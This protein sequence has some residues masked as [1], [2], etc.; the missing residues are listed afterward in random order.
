MRCHLKSGISKP[1]PNFLISLSLSGLEASQSYAS[2]EQIAC[3]A[4]V[5]STFLLLE[6]VSPSYVKSYLNCLMDSVLH[7]QTHVPEA[8][9]CS[10]QCHI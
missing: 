9:L 2:V 8:N 6:L 10:Q 3:P 1:L 7:Y 4:H 5:S